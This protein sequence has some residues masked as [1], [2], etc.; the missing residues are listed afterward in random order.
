MVHETL[1]AQP[2]VVN[3]KNN[4]LTLLVK[5]LSLIKELLFSVTGC[6]GVLYEPEYQSQPKETRAMSSG[7]SPSEVKGL[8]PVFY[9]FMVIEVKQLIGSKLACLYTYSVSWLLRHAIVVEFDTLYVCFQQI[10]LT[11]PA[12]NFI[13]SNVL[14]PSRF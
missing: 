12:L 10:G 4:S 14:V 8:W 3:F 1:C 9:L 2:S 7:C 6:S 13:K 11:F 5:R